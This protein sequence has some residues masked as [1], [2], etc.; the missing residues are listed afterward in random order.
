M[1]ARLV[2]VWTTRLRGAR[3][4]NRE[5]DLDDLIG[6]DRDVDPSIRIFKKLQIPGCGSIDG[7]VPTVVQT[8]VECVSNTLIRCTEQLHDVRHRV[9]VRIDDDREN[10]Q[11]LTVHT[12]F[13][14]IRTCLWLSIDVDK[15]DRCQ[16]AS[17]RRTKD[18]FHV[19]FV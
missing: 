11:C 3:W 13:N 19:T 14:V 12:D 7:C 2:S 6:I 8:V 17:L 16:G 9:V 10:L 15:T 5:H 18:G 4:L 1:T